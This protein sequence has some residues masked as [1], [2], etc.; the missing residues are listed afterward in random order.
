M[1]YIISATIKNQ[2]VRVFAIDGTETTSECQRIHKTFPVVTAAAGRTINAVAMMSMMLKNSN[3]KISAQLK[4]DGPVGNIL[5]VANNKGQI[6]ADVYN[7]FVDLPLNQIGKLD[8]AGAIGS[9]TLTVIKDI[10]LKNPYIGTVEIVS[11]EIA[12]DFTYYFA[13][14]EQTPSV[15]SLGVLVNPDGSVN[16][17]GGFII[18]LMPDYSEEIVQYIENRI[19]DMPS[20][21][22][23]M[24][25]GKSPKQ[26]IEMIFEEY[27]LQITN[28]R[29]I[30]YQ[31]DCSRERFMQ[32]IMSLGKEE[33]ESIINEDESAEVLCHFCNNKYDFTKEELQDLLEN[34]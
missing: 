14:S 3:D 15:V 33:I 32:G 27:E 21:T 8:V 11:G 30:E 4:C 13:V 5:V 23:L 18:Q 2:Q 22:K 9:G 19:S 10:G 1:D 24:E 17:S 12:E 31:C 25:M 7:P 29:E 34:I 26:I 28:K 20:I 16:K 6:K